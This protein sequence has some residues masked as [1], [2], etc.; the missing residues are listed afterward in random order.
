MKK[1]VTLGRGGSGK[2][3][4]V[5]LMTK[6]FIEKGETPILLIDAD[7][8]QNLS[9]MLGIDLSDEG[10]KTISELLV[11]T[12]M[13]GGGTTVGVPPSKRIESKIWETGLYE[14]DQFDFMAIGTKFIEGCYCLPNNA[15][16]TA[17]AGLTKTY[18]YVI[19]DSPGGLEHLNRRIASEVDD[20]F[21][22]IDPSQKS[23]HHVERAYK[24]AKDVDIKFNN[25]YVV[26]GNRVPES[27]EEEVQKRINLT[28]LGKISY[29]KEVEEAVLKGASLID[30]PNTSPAYVS[31]KK[32]LQKAGY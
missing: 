23:F 8:D 30:L 11:D 21:D 16:K 20:M 14:G 6:Y 13:E 28:Y 32:I 12:F 10:R 18:K 26:A 5:S 9:E 25:F 4:F 7:P 17:L 22:I 24:I 1:I 15:L 31:V 27:L 29:D 19:I 2:T 3:T